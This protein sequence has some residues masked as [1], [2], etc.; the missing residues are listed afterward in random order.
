MIRLPVTERSRPRCA[1]RVRLALLL[2]AFGATPAPAAEFAGGEE[3]VL[4]ADEVIDDDLVVAAETIRI[5]GRVEGDL[6]AAGRDIVVNGTVDEDFIAAGL[7][8]V[9]N[10]HVG[11]DIRIAGYALRFGEEARVGDDVFASGYSLET[12][13]GSLL[14]GNLLFAGFQAALAGRIEET[15]GAGVGALEL[16]G[17]IGEDAQLGVGASPAP[18]LLSFFFSPSVD[19]PAIEPRLTL[20]DSARIGGDLQYASP[21]PAAIHP[22]AKVAGEVRFEKQERSEAGGNGVDLATPLR[23]FVTVVAVGLLLLWCTPGGFERILSAGRRDPLPSLAWGVVLV[24]AVGL[25]AAVLGVVFVLLVSIVGGLTLGGLALPLLAVGLLLEL[26]LL[27]PSLTVAFYLPPALASVL[28]GRFVLERSRP[29]WL[30]RR[31]PPLLAGAAIW[32]VVLALPVVGR[33]AWLVVTLAGVGALFVHLRASA[34]G[35]PPAGNSG[36]AVGQP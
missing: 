25:V 32:V 18:P 12:L 5:D 16:R 36:A 9:V 10:G 22:H 4:P 13:D 34:A 21:E 17:E 15:L 26:A 20:A 11:D 23:R 7:T 14:G 35:E 24:L 3:Y 1:L 2:L 27:T 30:S 6:V 31:W 29:D 33:L 8:L 19:V 28:V